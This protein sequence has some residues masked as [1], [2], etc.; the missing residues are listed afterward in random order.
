MAC[1]LRHGPR[2]RNQAAGTAAN[3]AEGAFGGD[4]AVS[5][6]SDYPVAV[7]EPRH[8]PLGALRSALYLLQAQFQGS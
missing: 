4:W 1:P 7:D 2:L 8:S 3:S 5:A 6:E